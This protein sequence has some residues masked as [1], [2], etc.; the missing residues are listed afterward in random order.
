MLEDRIGNLW[1]GSEA[2]LTKLD[3][4]GEVRRIAFSQADGPNRPTRVQVNFLHEDADGILSYRSLKQVFSG[5]IKN[6]TVHEIHD[7]GWAS[8]QHRS[9]PVARSDGQLLDEHEQRPS[10]FNPRDNSF[11]NYT[12]SDVITRQPI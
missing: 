7:P 3:T 2:G 5:S 11:H 12:E 1:F 6:R 10:M 4:V 8:G 9:V